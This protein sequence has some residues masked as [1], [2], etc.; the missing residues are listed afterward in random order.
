MGRGGEAWCRCRKWKMGWLATDWNL[1]THP[2]KSASS[3]P[4]RTK[5]LWS[6]TKSLKVKSRYLIIP[7]SHRISSCY[8][9]IHFGAH[10]VDNKLS[11]FDPF[12][13]L[14]ASFCLDKNPPV[15]YLFSELNLLLS[16][17]RYVPVASQCLNFHF[18]NFVRSFYRLHSHWQHHPHHRHCYYIDHLLKMGRCRFGHWLPY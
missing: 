12:W 16:G 2:P 14:S 11:A 6:Q 10:S 18:A 15:F 8:G 17:G 9:H 1:G 3:S 7:T 4:S 13:D 5:W